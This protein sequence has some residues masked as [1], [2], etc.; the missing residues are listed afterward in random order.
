[1]QLSTVTKNPEAAD[2][3]TRIADLLSPTDPLLKLGLGDGGEAPDEDPDMPL[4][5]E[6]GETEQSD[7]PD[8]DQPLPEGS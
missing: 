6:Q 8:I 2:P 5:T 4:E 1:M 7:D 3:R